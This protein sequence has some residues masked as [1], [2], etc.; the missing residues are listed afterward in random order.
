MNELVKIVRKIVKGENSVGI[1]V[2]YFLG[3]ALGV[4]SDVYNKFSTN[5]LP[6]SSIRIK[7]F[8]K[9]TVFLSENFDDTFFVRPF[10]LTEAIERTLINEFIHPDHDQEIFYTE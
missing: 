5:K 7:K 10:K 1:R 9:S 3:Y 8:C 6:I 4:F 2:P